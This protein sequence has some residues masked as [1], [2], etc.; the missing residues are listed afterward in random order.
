MRPR[1]SSNAPVVRRFGVAPGMDVARRLLDPSLFPA[2]RDATTPAATRATTTPAA[3]IA[4]SPSMPG[5]RD[6]RPSTAA[7]AAVAGASAPATTEAA[8]ADALDADDDDDDVE[9][10]ASSSSTA[11][12]GMRRATASSFERTH[13]AAKRR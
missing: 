13:R 7:A 10:D 12:R 8:S 1:V 5:T 3:A 4:A 9:D 11:A 2:D 6:A